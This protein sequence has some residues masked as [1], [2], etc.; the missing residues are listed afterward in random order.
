MS[1][2]INNTN[3]SRPGPLSG[4]PTNGL[5]EKA[6][7]EVTKVFDAC[8]RLETITGVQL[9]ATNF[10][11]A[12]PTLPLTFISAET[13][14]S[15]QATITSLVIDRIESRPNYAYVNAT[16]S[17]PVIISYRDANGV[18]GTATSTYTTT[19]SVILFVP[20]PSLSPVVIKAVGTLTSSIGTFTEPNIFTLT[21]CVQV[22]LKVTA[23]VDILVPSYGYPN[24]PPCQSAPE[25]VCPG[26]T[27]LPIYPTAVCPGS[28]QN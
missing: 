18:L 3:P 25:S 12:N 5:C 24:L 23:D 7:I 16:I 20:Q 9:T 22:I 1:F 21:A 4:N 17:I 13:N 15:Q 2:Y 28:T 8:A 10:T 6:L 27:E 19:Q 14:T 26:G 11:P